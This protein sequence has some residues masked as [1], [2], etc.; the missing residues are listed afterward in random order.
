MSSVSTCPGL[1]DFA[2]YL[3]GQLPEQEQAAFTEHLV[4]CASCSAVIQKLQGGATVAA[5]KQEVSPPTVISTTPGRPA[6]P[7]P[8]DNG[9]NSKTVPRISPTIVGGD[10]L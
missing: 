6:S 3:L 1:Q 2:K 5:D 8:L 9:R 7:I 4:T 10:V